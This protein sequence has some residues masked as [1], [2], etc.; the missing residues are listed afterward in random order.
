MNKYYCICILGDRYGLA[1]L[2]LNL[3]RNEILFVY[4]PNQSY[5]RS[6]SF[7]VLLSFRNK[8]E[9]IGDFRLHNV[10]RQIEDFYTLLVQ[11]L[12]VTYKLSD[13]SWRVFWSMSQVA[14]ISSFP[15]IACHCKNPQSGWAPCQCVIFS[16]LYCHYHF[17]FF[18]CFSLLAKM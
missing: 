7:D 9:N 13:V 4:N 15:V 3:S 10:Q 12:T 6:S 17:F 5:N 11:R 1:R 8:H 14:G 18:F 16:N 2:S